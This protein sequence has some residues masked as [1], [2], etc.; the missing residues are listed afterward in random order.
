MTS[1]LLT[2]RS[3]ILGNG[4]DASDANHTN[5]GSSIV[6][7]ARTSGG[8]NTPTVHQLDRLTGGNRAGD[9]IDSALSAHVTRS[10]GSNTALTV[11]R[12]DSLCCETDA[13]Y[14]C[15]TEPSTQMGRTNSGGSAPSAPA[16]MRSLTPH[17]LTTPSASTQSA[18]S[19]DNMDKAQ[20]RIKRAQWIHH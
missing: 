16:T 14:S 17:G 18:P 1:H 5:G 19:A 13:D 9:I 12:A 3:N 4:S 15:S 20:H 11:H 10:S 7:I 8:G 6:H 2:A